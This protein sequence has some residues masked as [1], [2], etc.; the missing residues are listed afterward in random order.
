[1]E[2]SA[3][4]ASPLPE[5][6]L[7]VL[8]S[9]AAVTH[10]SPSNREGATQ[11]NANAVTLGA[12]FR[13]L[14]LL[15]LVLPGT[16]AIAAD[17]P[18][19]ITDFYQQKNESCI[20]AVI[21]SVPNIEGRPA[22]IQ[23]GHIN[24]GQLGFFADLFMTDPR[25][26]ARILALDA[27]PAA[28]LLFTEALYEAGL[29]TEAQTYGEASGFADALKSMRAMVLVQ[30]KQL[31]PA[32]NPA[33]NDIL[34]GAYMASG[35]TGYIKSIL[36]NFSS[37]SDDMAR[38]A[39][40]LSFVQT[41]FGPAATPPGREQVMMKAACLKYECQKGMLGIMRVM[42]LSSAFWALQ[43]LS[44]RDAGIKSTLAGFFEND[45]R[46]KRL[47][48]DE[49]NAF[50]NYMTTLALTAAIKDNENFNASLSIYER[51]GSGQDAIAAMMVRK[52]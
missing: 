52:N 26:K 1:L 44:Q 16:A 4:S 45:P 29:E 10:G 20:D 27:P 37:A 18:N 3:S 34:I 30:I 46:L 12:I 47:V 40:R 14:S 17:D 2:R 41:K 22:N 7:D 5:Q 11:M 33:D 31:K 39:L 24:P 8:V 42:T 36:E 32:A 21:K 48:A 6:P 15:L 51:L 23:G 43:S 50:G 19:C 38:D 13:I 9:F 25:Q 49:S 28:K 35:N